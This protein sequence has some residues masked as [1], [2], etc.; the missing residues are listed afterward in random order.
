MQII[1]MLMIA[2]HD[3]ITIPSQF[4]R[5]IKYSLCTCEHHEYFIES[6]PSMKD[7]LHV[8]YVLYIIRLKMIVYLKYISDPFRFEVVNNSLVMRKAHD[9]RAVISIDIE[10]STVIYKVT[11]TMCI[12][13]CMHIT[14]YTCTW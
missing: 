4:H 12:Y 9:I 3:T 2:I 13:C 11:Y 1:E 14:L 6:E 8:Y 5:G 10:V 7:S